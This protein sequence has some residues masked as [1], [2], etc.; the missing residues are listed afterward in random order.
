M[1]Y[2]GRSMGRAFSVSPFR[3]MW[4]QLPAKHSFSHVLHCFKVS[5]PY[6][7][8]NKVC[9]PYPLK[10]PEGWLNKICNG[11]GPAV[12]FHVLFT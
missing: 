1:V 9:R 5:S 6:S 12:H 3:G 8:G 10:M 2:E 11:Q 7:E 4:I